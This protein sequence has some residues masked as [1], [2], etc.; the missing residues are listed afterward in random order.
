MERMS[1]LELTRRLVAFNTINPPG[2]ERACVEFIAGILAGAGFETAFQSY[3]TDRTNLV[4]RL[5]GTEGER[6]PIVYSGHVDTVPLGQAPWSVSPFDGEVKDGKVYGRGT[7][8]MKSGVAA[9]VLAALSLA[10]LPRRRADVT[11][12]ISAGEETGCE[13][14]RALAARP[15]LLGECGALVIAEPTDNRPLVG[16]KGALWMNIKVPGVTAHGSMPEKGVNAIV[17][18]CSVVEALQGFDFD[19]APHP[20]MG[21]PTLNVGTIQGGLNINSVPDSVSLGVDIR[22]IVGQA[23]A[24]VRER[25]AAALSEDVQIAPVCDLDHV[26][27][28]PDDPWMRQAFAIV[29]RVL[30][31]GGGVETASYFTDAS[32]LTPAYGGPPTLILGPGP[33]AMAHQTDEYCHVEN[34]DRC[35]DAFTAIGTD[36]LT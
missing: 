4:A 5:P 15:D 9:F 6:K 35:T 27:T 30:G 17:K 14:V 26:Y 2:K 19:V 8:D 28:D 12:V 10:E 24:E 18:A 1:G 16:H 20:V 33:M 25:I 32:V 36:Y 23:N 22:T 21:S 29:G 31:T 13:G 11:L 34:I 7:C 3:D